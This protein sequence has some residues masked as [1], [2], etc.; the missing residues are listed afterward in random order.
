VQDQ[1]TPERK[2]LIRRAN[3]SPLPANFSKHDHT[4][5]QLKY[6]DSVN[7]PKI[8]KTKI[9]KPTTKVA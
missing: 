9:E 5:K 4:S 1:S 7:S 2:R 8:G 3:S 6:T